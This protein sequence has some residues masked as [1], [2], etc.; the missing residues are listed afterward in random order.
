KILTPPVLS[1][2]DSFM[3]LLLHWIDGSALRITPSMDSAR[4]ELPSWGLGLRE[5][6]K[7][8]RSRETF[9]PRIGACA[10]RNSQGGSWPTRGRPGAGTPRRSARPFPV[11]RHQAGS[12]G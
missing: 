5:R 9:R 7:A 2:D 4:G 8:R 6:G 1:N 11:P 10:A 12:P 3:V